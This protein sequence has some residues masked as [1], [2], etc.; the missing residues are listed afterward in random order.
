MT[1]LV[2]RKKSE[3]LHT[4][5]TN[6]QYRVSR[7]KTDLDRALTE[8][9][10]QEKAVENGLPYIDLYGFPIDSSII[11]IIPKQAFLETRLGVFALLNKELHLVTDH[12]NFAGQDTVLASLDAKDYTYKMYYGSNLS[13]DKLTRTFDQLIEVHDFEDEINLTT[14]EI[15]EIKRQGFDLKI[16][17]ERLRK[18][19]TTEILDIVFAAAMLN[20]AT[21]IHF[22]PEE[23]SYKIRL[24][25]DGILYSLVEV[26]KTLQKPVESRI[27]ILAKVKLNLDN[28][29]QDG[30]ITFGYE[31]KVIDVRVSFL[32]SNY[33]YSIVMR[34]LGTGA[35]TL[36]LDALGFQGQA[37]ID[38]ERAINKPQGMILTTG[39]TGSGKTTT[40]YT[41]LKTLNDGSSKIITLEDPIE[42]RL[43]GLSQTQIDAAAG[44]TFASGLRSILRQDPDVVMVGEIRDPET[45]DT[46]IQAALTGH[47][48]LSTIHTND[49]AGAI[50]RLIELGIR[51]FAISDAVS[52]IL[53]QRLVR[54]LC[55]HCKELDQITDEQKSIIIR[56]LS[57][58]L[59]SVQQTLP[60]PL[61]FWTAKGCDKCN[62]TGYKGRIG[63]YEV[64][65]IS[66]EIR[67]MLLTSSPSTTLIRKL[68]AR[69][70][71]LN[72]LQ[73]GIIKSLQG[74]T[75]M[76]EVLDNIQS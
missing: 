5:P 71:M 33:G 47:Q 15:E 50:P 2:Q 20:G 64:L 62:Q 4:I 60:N 28:I 31:K 30:R 42:Y 70:G 39:P 29:A 58:L 9:L 19:S 51:G 18:A 65:T 21:D 55:T 26:K 16:L 25:L 36:S 61:T 46:A 52:V 72:M 76:K 73:D 12:P 59:P 22:E 44:Y 48:V 57:I 3:T 67:E 23:A 10:A 24:R 1:M 11:S 41:I 34:L 45:A 43:E 38:I 56:E 37:K 66:D 27:K 74:I 54:K 40:L 75:D 53:G 35:V 49:A 13:I 32:P 14:E 17:S 68:A 7:V 6:R 8:S 69:G 63:V